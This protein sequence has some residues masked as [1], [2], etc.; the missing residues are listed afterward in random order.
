MIQRKISMLATAIFL[1]FAACG[2]ASAQGQRVQTGRPDVV[3]AAAVPAGAC[4]TQGVISGP[5][6]YNGN[7]CGSPSAIANYNTTLCNA[8]VDGYPGPEQIWQVNVGNSIAATILLTPTAADLGV[9]LVS[10]CGVGLSCVAYRDSI[11][12][13]DG[14]AIGVTAPNTSYTAFPASNVPAGT[15][16]AYVDSYYASG[17]DSCGPY[18]LAIAGSLPVELTNFK[19]D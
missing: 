8:I 3:P 17:P 11:G 15:Y 1:T 2:V 14:I 5:G 7:N 12:S 10:Q 6:S 16:Y 19:I 9:F 18:T 13:P 4:T